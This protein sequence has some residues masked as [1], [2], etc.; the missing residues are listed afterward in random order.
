MEEQKNTA[1]VSFGSKGIVPA[2]GAVVGAAIA[3]GVPWVVLANGQILGSE[4]ITRV[5]LTAVFGGCIISLVSVFFGLVIPSSVQGNDL[6]T[7]RKLKRFE[8]GD[9]EKTNEG[10]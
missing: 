1:S 3:I 5:I 8:A 6:E 10:N 4:T 7:L 9:R 2:S